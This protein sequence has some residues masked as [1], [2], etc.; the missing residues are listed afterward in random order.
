MLQQ[1]HSK[2][3]ELYQ[4]RRLWEDMSADTAAATL[5]STLTETVDRQREVVRKKLA[6]SSV[7]LAP[8]RWL[9]TVGALIW[10]PFVQPVL[11]TLLAENRMNWSIIHETHELVVLA[12]RIFSVT[13]LLQNLTF[14]SMYFFVL[15]VILR[16]DT[17]RRINRFVAKWK[18]DSSDLSLTLQT[19][20]WLDELLSPIK[21]AKERYN[22]LVKRTNEQ[23]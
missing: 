6:G 8:F 3:S 23:K 5:R 19:M 12:V 16:W 13:E 21:N 22:Q 10:F 20:H 1:S 11:E 9:L 17:Q 7:L 14:L 2:V 15:W 18:S 4:N